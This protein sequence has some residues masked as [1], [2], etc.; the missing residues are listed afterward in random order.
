MKRGLHLEGVNTFILTF[1]ANGLAGVIERNQGLFN[2][3]LFSTN[4]VNA[5]HSLEIGTCFIQFSNSVKEEE[6]LKELN[7][8]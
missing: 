2:T 5:L 1:D 8:I 3:G 6:K 4:F 7:K